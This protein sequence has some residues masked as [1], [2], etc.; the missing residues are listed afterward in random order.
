M[1]IGETN[2]VSDFGYRHGRVGQERAGAFDARLTV[3]LSGRHPVIGP[4]QGAEMRATESHFGRE[5]FV[6]QG[7]V[8]VWELGTPTVGNRP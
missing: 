2:G 6:S 8:G 7:T 5:I 3:H 4:E 1:D